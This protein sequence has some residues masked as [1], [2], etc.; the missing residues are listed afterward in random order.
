MEKA[1]SWMLV[2]LVIASCLSQFP[3]AK[4]VETC[5]KNSDCI[6]T[7]C[8]GSFVLCVNGI[9]TCEVSGTSRDESAPVTDGGVVQPTCTV[10]SQCE[11]LRPW[12]VSGKP[13]CF[14]GKC[15]CL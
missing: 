9:C 10:S 6:R 14:N 2:F 13:T 3:E 1:I 5:H 15:V 8:A 12:C 4:S 7:S 11:S